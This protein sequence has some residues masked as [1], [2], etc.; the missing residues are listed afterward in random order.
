MRRARSLDEWRRK[1]VSARLKLRMGARGLKTWLQ[2]GSLQEG[3]FT[4]GHRRQVAAPSECLPRTDN[5]LGG[6]VLEGAWA[7]HAGRGPAGGACASLEA[8]ALYKGF[9]LISRGLPVDR[10]EAYFTRRA[11]PVADTRY[12]GGNV[13]RHGTAELDA[14]IK[15][16][17]TT[18]PFAERSGI[19]GDIMHTQTDQLTMLPVFFQGGAYVLGS[20]RLKNVQGGQVWNAHLWDLD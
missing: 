11:I 8:R 15:R 19:L 9:F 2:C 3:I 7:G 20:N 17:I 10:P 13:A 6:A 5:T 14:L 1:W 16:Y 4:M 18:I 12:R